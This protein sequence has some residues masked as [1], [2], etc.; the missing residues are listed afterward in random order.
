MWTEFRHSGILDDVAWWQSLSSFLGTLLHVG[1]SPFL[2][3]LAPVPDA[4]VQSIH[5]LAH[6]DMMVEA[7][8]PGRQCFLSHKI[9]F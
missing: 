6:F 2:S 9:L 3:I 7:I 4:E 8:P 1:L 5:H